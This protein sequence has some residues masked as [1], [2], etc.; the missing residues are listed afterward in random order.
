MTL[1]VL[2]LT[3][4]VVACTDDAGGRFHPMAIDS[5]LTRAT[6]AGPG[7][8]VSLDSLGPSDWTAMYVFGPYTTPELMRRCMTPAKPFEGYGLERG[9][10]M[11]AIMFRRPNGRVSSMG[12]LRRGFAFAPEAVSREY[13]RGSASFTVRKSPSGRLNE[14]VASG[15]ETRVCTMGDA[16]PRADVQ[17]I[18]LQGDTLRSMPLSAETRERY[19]RQLAEARAAYQRAPADVDSIIWYGRRL[20][21]PGHV[22]EA[23]EAYTRGIELYPKDARLYRHRGHRYITVRELDN[24]IADLEQARKLVAGRPDEV[25]PDG[26][27]NARNTPIGT[28]QSN[29]DYH[30]GLAYYLKGDFARALPIYQREF[31]NARNDDRRV[32][33]AHWLYMSLRRLGRDAEAARVLT[34]VRRD[35]DVIENQSYH[36]LL[37]MYKGA[38]PADSVLGMTATGEM[39]VA[40]ATAAYGIG[41]WHLY[42]GRRAEATRVF[43]RIIAGGQWGAFGYIAAEAEL[44]RLR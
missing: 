30:L 25:E 39:S 2:A 3:V 41:N 8:T 10:G 15:R 27:P 14:L 17:A 11:Y 34:S 12:L 7:T 28:L 9:D 13:S 21:Y 35:M 24:A 44:A 19:E 26:Q 33:I 5:V 23:I 29:I 37:L 20:A 4:L 32:S 6:M 1:R 16:P 40:D 36:R 43:E 38:L 22:R 18:S 42:N 31:A